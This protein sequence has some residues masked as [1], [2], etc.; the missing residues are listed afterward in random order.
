MSA[1]FRVVFF[2]TEDLKEKKNSAHPFVEI[3]KWKTCARFEQKK[4]NSELKL[5]K[6]FNL[7]DKRPGFSD[8]RELSVYFYGILYT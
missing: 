2:I 8:K 5:M 1:K 3:V 6:V 7:S 4:I